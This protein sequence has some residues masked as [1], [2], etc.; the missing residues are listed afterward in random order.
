[1]NGKMTELAHLVDE[2]GSICIK[3]TEPKGRGRSPSYK[4]SLA[5]EIEDRHPIQQFCTFFGTHTAVRKRPPNRKVYV[6]EVGGERGI[7]ILKRLSPHLTA[8]RTQAK[9]AIDFYEKTVRSYNPRSKGF[10]RHPKPA[11][12]I[13]LQDAYWKKLRAL[14]GN[15]K[16]P[17]KF[18]KSA[19][20]E[21]I[22]EIIK[23]RHWK[24]KK[25]LHIIAK[26][27]NLSWGGLQWYLSTYD[28]PRRGRVESMNVVFNGHGPNF[29]GG[30]VIITPTKTKTGYQGNPY[31]MLKKPGHSNAN[32][33][34]YVYEHRYVLAEHYGRPINKDEIVHH[35]NGNTLDNR[36]ENLE[37]RKRAGKDKPHGPLTVCPHC[38]ESLV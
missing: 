33:K 35:K 25:S 20:G 30:R 12:L 37:L 38:G 6:I 10:N 36:L 7:E 26:E 28:I 22:A 9:T 24:E 16:R 8:K 2:K 4:Y 32:K 17:E 27:L 34:G 13:S 3:R 14:N 29:K 31:V 21:R 23:Q 1:M 15:R 18:A 5:I 11:K 19:A